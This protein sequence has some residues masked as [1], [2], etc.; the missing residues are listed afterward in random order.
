M[1]NNSIPDIKLKVTQLVCKIAADKGVVFS[2]DRIKIA[3]W[4]DLVQAIMTLA[5][6]EETVFEYPANW[7]EALKEW[8][9]KKH[10]IGSHVIKLFKAVR[11]NKVVAVH[12]FP[13]LVVPSEL[14]G[15]EF[16][17]LKVMPWEE[18]ERNV[19]TS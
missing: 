19:L 7:W 11:Y 15:R 18:V 8:L 10:L 4:E 1:E 9:L 13:E 2:A 14:L 3:A 16:V 17:H 5:T 6:Q 12:K